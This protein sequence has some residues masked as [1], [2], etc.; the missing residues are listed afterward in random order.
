ME[1][2]TRTLLGTAIAALFATPLANAGTSLPPS[3]HLSAAARKAAP[4]QPA[5]PTDR[6]VVKFRDDVPATG[7]SNAMARVAASNGMKA[8]VGRRLAVGANVVRL[9]RKLDHVRVAAL[10]AQLRADPAVEYAVVDRMM[11]RLETPPAP[12]SLLFAPTDPDYATDQW[13]YHDPV[14]GINAEGAWDVVRGAGAVVAVLDTGI[15]DHPDLIGNT[16]AGGYDFISDGAVG[17]DGGGRDNDPHDPGDFVAADQCGSGSTEEASSWHGTHVAGTVAATASNGIGGTG[18][19]FKAKVLPVRVLGKCGGYNSDIADA[20]VWA[21]GGTVPGVPMNA[22]P[23]EVINMSLGGGGSCDPMT[24]EAINTAVAN[25]SVVVVAAGNSY[26]SVEDFSPA[27]CQ[28]VIT[29]ASNDQNGARSYFSNAGG[30]IDVAGPGGSPGIHSTVNAGATVPG[31]HVYG[32]MQGTSMAAPHVAGI[33]A[34]MQALD[35]NS[36][37]RVE[38]LLKATARAMP[39]AACPGT[40]GAGRVDASAAIDAVLGVVPL[41]APTV[42]RNGVTQFVPEGAKGSRARYIFYTYNT[43]NNLKFALAGG[44]GNADLYVRYGAMPTTTTYDC[45]SDAAGNLESCPIASPLAGKYYVM[46]RGGAAHAGARLTAS[47]NGNTWEN[48]TDTP[49]RDAGTWATS[50]LFVQKRAGNASSAAPVTVVLQH[51]WV[52]DLSATLQAPD[53]TQYPLFA[54]GG[55]S[56]SALNET[57]LVNLSSEA[58]NGTWTLLVK[59]HAGVDVG[60]IDNFRMKL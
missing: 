35:P 28:N 37:A 32:T 57:F 56:G 33:A 55:R 43:L 30:L 5:A 59:D 6:L 27:S 4:I 26:S 44:T 9:D 58:K 16:L 47:Y 52:G 34:L 20:I 3:Q 17:G 29:V 10:L 21:S 14:G 50:Q 18:V 8:Q 13:H 42:L 54:Q 45:R 40:C 2:L 36:P 15:T 46:V 25:G 53:G 12:P 41:A 11:H 19:A 48:R 7:R 23:A 31:A 24:Q 60:H 1:A 39:G 22:N 51:T 38:E 49:I